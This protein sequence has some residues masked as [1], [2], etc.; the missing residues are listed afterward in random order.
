MLT[1]LGERQSNP[2]CDGMTRR[3]FLSVGGLAMGGIALPD[4]LLAERQ[5]NIAVSYTHLTLPTI[6][7]V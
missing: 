2:F 6:C 4:L 5:N 7:S 1:V 3:N